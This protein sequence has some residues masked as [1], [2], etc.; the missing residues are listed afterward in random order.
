LEGGQLTP[1]EAL[2]RCEENGSPIAQVFAG[3]VRKWGRP[4]V[5]VE[6]AMLDAGER[7]ATTLRR[8]LRALNTIHTVSPLLG[9]LGTVFGMIDC[10]KVVSSSQTMGRPDLLASGISEALITTAAGLC[11]AIPTLCFYLYFCSCADRRIVEIDALGQ[12]VVQLIC[13]GPPSSG[14]SGKTNKKAA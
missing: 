9:L 11:V 3:A 14:R 7:V 13:D 8:N 5:E 1:A 2:K 4:S 12:Q 6:Q 10:F